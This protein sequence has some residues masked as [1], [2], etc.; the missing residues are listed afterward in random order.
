MKKRNNKT[1][2]IKNDLDCSFNLEEICKNK[3]YIRNI[4]Q[5]TNYNFIKNY[6]NIII[7]LCKIDPNERLELKILNNIAKK[8]F[9]EI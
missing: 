7:G 9:L 2:F 3:K 4:E 1:S 8:D 6:N 5:Y